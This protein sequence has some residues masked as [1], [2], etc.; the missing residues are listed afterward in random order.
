MAK[1]L[2]L[3]ESAAQKRLTR[4]LGKLR[5]QV[6][7]GGLAPDITTIAGLLPVMLHEAAPASQATKVSYLLSATLL[8]RKLS[9]TARMESAFF[10][11]LHAHRP[12]VAGALLALNTVIWAG[13]YQPVEPAAGPAPATASSLMLLNGWRNLGLGLAFVVDASFTK[14]G[15]LPANTPGSS[16]G[17]CH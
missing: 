14:L 8:E 6:A 5:T 15:I 2:G 16:S 13:V 11:I 10:R 3:T 4:A 1:V 7:L 17:S 12:A 9:W